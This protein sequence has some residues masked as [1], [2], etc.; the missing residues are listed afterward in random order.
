MTCAA[1][2]SRVEKVLSRVP[3]VTEVAVNMATERVRVAREATARP[4]HMGSRTI[5][6][7]G[8]NKAAEVVQLRA[9]GSVVAIVD[10]G[11]VP[12]QRGRQRFIAAALA[13]LT[14]Y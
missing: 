7:T 3:G 2:G 13:A 12:G 4:R 9:D 11:L 8:T 5:A 10:D 14:P 6:L 1:C